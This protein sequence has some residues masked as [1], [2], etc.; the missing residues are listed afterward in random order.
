MCA[1]PQIIQLPF[2]IT[3]SGGV[4][5]GLGRLYGVDE[6]LAAI[7][8]SVASLANQLLFHITNY[9]VGSKFNL[10]PAAIYAGTNALSATATILALQQ[11]ELISQRF[12]GMLIAGAAIIFI[13]RLKILSA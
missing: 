12:A 5:Y 10:S 3:I 13:S 4:G 9:A 1:T 11:M 7:T 6:R 2:D 8:L